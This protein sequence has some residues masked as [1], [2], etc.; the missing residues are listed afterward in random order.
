MRHTEAKGLKKSHK[1]NKRG[2]IIVIIIGK[3]GKNQAQ[4]QEKQGKAL[5]NPKK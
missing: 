4:S 2:I 1:G 3:Q 5:E